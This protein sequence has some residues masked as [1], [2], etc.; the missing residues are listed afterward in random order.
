MP[1]E[2][3]HRVHGFS[4]IPVIHPALF[5]DDCSGTMNWL[6]SGTGADYSVQ[7]DPLAAFVQTNG[8][9]LKTRETNPAE[10]DIVNAY[11]RLWLPPRGVLRLQAMFSFIVE[12]PPEII[13]FII[14]WNDGEVAHDAGIAIWAT[15]GGVAYL[16]GYQAGDFVW[17]SIPDWKASII[18]GA[19]SNIDFSINLDT[20]FYHRIQLNEHVLD[21]TQIPI[22]THDLLLEKHLHLLLKLK[23]FTAA[24]A[25]AYV[26]Q[27]LLTQEAP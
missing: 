9:M 25:S 3:Y 17:T 12:T 7:Y 10:E 4:T 27:I 23:A 1:Q 14:T 24:Q 20:G 16:S 19:W 22:H 11:R 2:H 26:D 8:L 5:F 13:Q 6:K 18:D 15:Y 21:G